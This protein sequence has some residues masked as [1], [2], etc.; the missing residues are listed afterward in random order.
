LNVIGAADQR[1]ISAD[2]GADSAVVSTISADIASDVKWPI[3][4]DRYSIFIA[5]ASASASAFFFDYPYW[6]A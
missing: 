2:F 5:S 3:T 1:S 4:I 6:R